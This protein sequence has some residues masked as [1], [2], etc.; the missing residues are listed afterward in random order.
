MRG[1]GSRCCKGLEAYFDQRKVVGFVPVLRVEYTL[2]EM[3]QSDILLLRSERQLDIV[4]GKLGLCINSGRVCVKLRIERLEQTQMD[5][6]VTY[7]IL[8]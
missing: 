1:I 3:K 5:N 7:E 4:Q 8:N 2:R 6:V